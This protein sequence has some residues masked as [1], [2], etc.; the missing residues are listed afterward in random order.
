MADDAYS[1]NNAITTIGK[2]IEGDGTK[3]QGRVE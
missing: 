2:F 1:Y 3:V